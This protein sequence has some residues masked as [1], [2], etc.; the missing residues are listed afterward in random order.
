[1]REQRETVSDTA[2][3]ARAREAVA[4]AKRRLEARRLA[5]EDAQQ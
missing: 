1:M 3:I 4:V 5:V 2:A